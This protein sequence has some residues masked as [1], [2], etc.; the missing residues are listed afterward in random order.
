MEMISR[1]RVKELKEAGKKWCSHCKSELDYNLF[2]PNL[3]TPCG[4]E[5]WCRECQRSRKKEWQARNKEANLA[6]QK[7]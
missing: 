6:R 1:Q 2:G 4:R 5:Y 3:L 7:G